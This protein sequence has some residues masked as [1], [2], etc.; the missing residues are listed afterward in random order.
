MQ[1]HSKYYG[2]SFP[3]FALK[4][5]PYD[6]VIRLDSIAVQM[7]EDADWHTID[8]YT[9]KTP[10]LNR[11]VEVKDEFFFFDY[12]CT[13]LTQLI[14]KKIEWAI[15]ARAKI[16]DLRLKQTFKAR[17]VSVVKTRGNLIWVDTVSYPFKLS[18][19]ILDPSIIREQ[20]A[21]IVYIDQ[22]WYLYK[23]SSFKEPTKE[24]TL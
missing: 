15:D 10:L 6:F 24:L 11:Y 23:F 18:K 2:I 7:Q 9:D 3:V 5:K 12:T 22:V 14:S 13:N 19:N 17:T 8:K 16:Y 21:T 4:K 20:Y 1:A